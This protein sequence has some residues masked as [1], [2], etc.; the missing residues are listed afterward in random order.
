MKR[1]KIIA[2]GTSVVAL[3]LT[4]ALS[5]AW[6][7]SSLSTEAAGVTTARIKITKS[8]DQ[9]YY[10]GSVADNYLEKA[11]AGETIKSVDNE[12][13]AI[14]NESTRPAFAKIEFAQ[15]AG[16]LGEFDTEFDSETSD[17]YSSAT[18]GT[19]ADMLALIN[20]IKSASGANV[21]GSDV[22]KGLVA[23]AT[24]VD[25][26]DFDT[27]KAFLDELGRI[28]RSDDSDDTDLFAAPILE[29]LFGTGADKETV[30][31][32]YYIAAN[33]HFSKIV[34]ALRT[35]FT[36]NIIAALEGAGVPYYIDPDTDD[37]YVGLGV[38]RDEY[39]GEDT[40]LFD[41][42]FVVPVDLGGSVSTRYTGT[43]KIDGL[44]SEGDYPDEH[45][46]TLSYQIEVKAV[47]A[48]V[49]AINDVFGEVGTDLAGDILDV[50][51]I[52]SNSG[53]AN[54]TTYPN[55]IYKFFD[56]IITDY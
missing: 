5:F 33:Q 31:G 36:D 42:G 32:T 38:P 37:F 26:S 13:F 21:T 27:Y 54:S 6:L 53:N 30:L 1:K 25:T 47:Q 23:L 39:P 43:D 16:K 48:T 10:I 2:L 56:D 51:E 17:L 9:T 52:A 44:N 50:A 8:N 24:A 12:K 4:A 45:V 3:G 11:L 40:I 18:D 7:T 14:K 46:A 28:I 20:E 41:L 49:K 35:Q 22:A 19:T 15:F 55:R 29:N 34:D